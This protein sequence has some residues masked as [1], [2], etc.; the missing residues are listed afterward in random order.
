MLYEIPERPATFVNRDAEM[1][2]ISEALTGK[3]PVLLQ[4]H[5]LGGVGKTSL[6]LQYLYHA[7]MEYD[8]D[9]FDFYPNPPETLQ[10]VREHISYSYSQETGTVVLDGAEALSGA[11]TVSIVLE[12]VRK[13]PQVSIII[14]SR[15]LADFDGRLESRHKMRNLHLGPLSLQASIDLLSKLSPA[16]SGEYSVL[17]KR[18]TGHPLTLRLIAGLTDSYDVA[19]IERVLDGSLYELE[20]RD[21]GLVKVVRPKIISASE[22][23][24]EALRQRPSEID[25]ITPRQFE[26]V[27]A[28]LLRDMGWGVELTKE[29][30]D[31]GFDILAT[32]NTGLG[33][34]ICL[35]EAKKYRKDRPVGVELVRSLYGTLVDHGANSSL[36]VTTSRFSG[37]AREFQAKHRYQVQ[38][39]EYIDLV[40][41]L[42][43]Y[44]SNS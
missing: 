9:W 11:E 5:G 22:H 6:L 39:R 10:Y 40:R 27:V 30:R 38:L 41:W 31:G 8:V 21:A 26:G 7:K 32:M 36:L 16:G 20:R 33:P 1:E 4:I 28:E 29:T 19:E 15:Y 34:M 37:D 13:L 2:F 25:A 12:L 14:T 35:V 3:G 43:D 44:G 23:L 18:S 17:A 42:A 24:V